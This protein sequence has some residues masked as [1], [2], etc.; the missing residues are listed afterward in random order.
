[1][2]SALR[3]ALATLSRLPAI[4]SVALVR[5][6]QKTLSPDH[7]LLRNLYPYGYCRHEPTCSEYAVEIL[8]T[9]SYPVAVALIMKRIAGCHP[10]TEP[11]AERLQTIIL[12]TCRSNS[13]TPASSSG[14][15]ERSTAILAA[16]S[17]RTL[18]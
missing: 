17:S 9:K 13:H 1:M 15:K 16:N 2:F 14:H 11:S 10:W 12:K 4:V 6:Y 3:K 7:G 18:S 8:K 5:L